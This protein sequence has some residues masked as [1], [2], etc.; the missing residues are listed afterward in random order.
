MAVKKE[1]ENEIATNEIQEGKAN[2]EIKSDSALQKNAGSEDK[3]I[4]SID[5]FASAAY[6]LFKVGPDLVVAALRSKNLTKCTKA[7]AA[8]AVK[9]FVSKEVK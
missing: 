2:E 4:Y 6:S 9:D 1:K 7:E 5:D 8:A 3:S